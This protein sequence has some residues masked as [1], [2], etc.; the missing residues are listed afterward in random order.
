MPIHTTDTLLGAVSGKESA[1]TDR[2]MTALTA[3][4]CQRVG[5]LRMLVATGERH[6]PAVLRVLVVDGD[7][8]AGRLGRGPAPENGSEV[9]VFPVM[10]GRPYRAAA[11]VELHDG[12]RGRLYLRLVEQPESMDG[13]GGA[14]VATDM[15]CSEAVAYGDGG[16]PERL[17]C[18]LLELSS[19]GAQALVSHT[20]IEGQT[21]DLRFVLDGEVALDVSGCV[22]WT[23]QRESGCLCGVQFFGLGDATADAIARH[24]LFLQRASTHLWA[25]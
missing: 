20:V 14:R 3:S 12:S 11:R 21:L 7:L 6:E 23:R 2:E 18:R 5:G 16:R 25:S 22:R 8:V 4:S 24:V 9:T 1:V 10:N 15:Q 13:G 17:S 19:G